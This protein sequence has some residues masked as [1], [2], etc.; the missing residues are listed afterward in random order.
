MIHAAFTL[1]MLVIF[2]AISA[3]PVCVCAEECKIVDYADHI[4][5][6]C[7]GNPANNPVTAPK[8]SSSPE[9]PIQ[10]SSDKN[11][12]GRPAPDS[13]A[14]PNGAQV[15]RKRKMLETIRTLNNH[16]FDTVD[17]PPRSDAAK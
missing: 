3:I 9:S 11:A 8:S 16:R 14:P 12:Q 10:E 2:A 5:V 7:V 13:D 17:S 6:A 1:S 15:S 4:E